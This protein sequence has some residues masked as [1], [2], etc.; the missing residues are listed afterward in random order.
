MIPA[1][2]FTGVGQTFGAGT[3]AT[4]ALQSGLGGAASS[5]GG[6]AASAGMALNPIGLAL[7]G[8]QLALGVAQMIQ[9]GKAREQQVYNQTYQNTLTQKLNEYARQQKNEQIASAFG[10]KLDFV[11]GQIENNFLAAQASW[12]SEQMRLNEIYGRA[13]FR[14]QT[15]QRQLAQAVGSAAAREVYG[16]SAR[17]GALVST[18]GAYGRTRAQLVE[19]LLSEKTATKMRMERTE[20]QKRSRDKLAIAQVANLP[21]PFTAIAQSPSVAAGGRGLGIAANIMGI[22]QQAFSAY[23]SV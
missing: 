22:G 23:Q 12:T 16:K 20:Q 15:M 10:A 11:K 17:R 3:S 13:A 19:Q 1:S 4:S 5:G 14:S 6:A 18:L 8:G 2:G 7:A 9:A 21:M